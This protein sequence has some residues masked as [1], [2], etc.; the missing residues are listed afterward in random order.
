MVAESVRFFG[1]PKFAGST[2]WFRKAIVSGFWELKIKVES[3]RGGVSNGGVPAGE[4]FG[5]EV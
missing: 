3:D 5:V 4:K 2:V 1:V